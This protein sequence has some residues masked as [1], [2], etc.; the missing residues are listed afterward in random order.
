MQLYFPGIF[1][2]KCI[3]HSIHLCCN[4]ACKCL[5]RRC[6]DLARNICNFFS[7]N[8]KRLS[9]FVQFQQFLNL[10]V[11]KMQHTSQTRWLSLS[12]VD[13]LQL[14]FTDK[15][16]SGILI[17]AENIY[18]QLNDP[19]TKA[20]F[21]FLE[22]VLPKFT[23]L[24]QFFQTENVVLTTLIEKMELVFKEILLCYM[25]RDY[26]MKTDLRKI[27]PSDENQFLKASTI[28]LVSCVQIKK[29]YDFSNPILPLL[30]VL[31]PSVA[32]SI[33]K[34]DIYP[35]IYNLM[36]HLPR[37]LSIEDNI[38]LQK[39][40]VQWRN[41]PLYKLSEN[42]INERESDRFWAYIKDLE[43]EK[44]KDLAVFSTSVL[45]LPHSNASC[46]RIF[47][48]INSVKTKSRNKLI[49][50]TVSATV[51][52]SESIKK[53]NGNCISFKPI[54]DML[55]RMTSSNL[56]PIAADIT[57]NNSCQDFNIED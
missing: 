2:I 16:L 22:W 29:R 9:Q 55:A 36:Q 13:A 31:N 57:Q 8:S 6:E 39:I 37:L 42:I 50:S 1:I 23:S 10:N 17:S 48:K 40:D 44:F 28:Y 12:S 32:L 26:V 19:F 49:T 54:K 45:C 15:W 20:Y 53:D 56:Y 3:C 46:E 51:I 41:L 34:R 18:F 27:N 30:N 14:Y 25:K 4:E 7:H 21:Y 47:S 52:S 33:S 35:S 24:N 11:H 5:P 38:I 43:C